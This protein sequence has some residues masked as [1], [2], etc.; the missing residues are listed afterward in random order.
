MDELASAVETDRLAEVSLTG[1]MD[2]PPATLGHAVYPLLPR[3]VVTLW[4][5]HGGTG[6]STAV[7]TLAAHG[8]CGEPWAGSASEGRI[9][10]LYVSLEDAGDVVRYRLRRICEAYNLDPNQVEAN[11]HVLESDS[12][13]TALMRE[14][15]VSGFRTMSETLLMQELESKTQGADVIIIDNASDAYD[16]NENERRFVRAFLRRLGDIAKR[17]SAALVLLAHIDKNS[18]RNGASG[19]SYAGSTAWH[20]SA[21]S[22]VA[23]IF[24]DKDKTVE[25]VHEKHNFGKR[26]DSFRFRFNDHGVLVPLAGGDVTRDASDQA[27]VLA[28]LRAADAAGILVPVATSGPATALHAVKHLPEMPEDLVA[29]PRRFH[30]LLEKLARSGTIQR[31]AYKNQNRKEKER[32]ELAQAT[33]A[34]DGAQVRASIPYPYRGT[35]AL[36]HHAQSP[37][38]AELAHDWS[39]GANGAGN[40]VPCPGSS[41]TSNAWH[42]PAPTASSPKADG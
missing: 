9:R 36:A 2:A 24:D 25:L 32:W 38:G 22:R 33:G 31:V 41:T 20:N 18:A 11:V 12:S 19:N 8:A 34:G 39:T 16:G 37:T 15:L 4:G 40:A 27:A 28:V 29:N 17:H 6:K 14:D 26:A 5:G 35:G 7:L 10:C 1:F 42:G 30:S 21:R 23:M 3:S 13:D